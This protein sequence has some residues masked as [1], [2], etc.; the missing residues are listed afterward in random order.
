MQYIL[1]YSHLCLV[2]SPN[3][4][5]LQP[6]F[7][8]F[9]SCPIIS[10]HIMPIV[11]GEYF[12]ILFLL[13]PPIL[14]IFRV[15]LK[16][17]GHPQ[18]KLTWILQ[19]DMFQMLPRVYTSQ[20]HSEDLR[21]FWGNMKNTQ[22]RQFC[23]AAWIQRRAFSHQL[24]HVLQPAEI[25]AVSRFRMAPGFRFSPCKSWQGRMRMYGS[26]DGKMRMFGM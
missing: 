23:E 10:P 15:C 19:V 25:T 9:P 18:S 2:N 4:W 24:I 12:F 6:I 22:L 5:L 13:L 14:T 17:M 16:M 3:L 26:K 11:V 8:D 1:F 7:L 20:F 21:F